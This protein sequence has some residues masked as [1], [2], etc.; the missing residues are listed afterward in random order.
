MARLGEGSSQYRP[1][2][3]SGGGGCGSWSEKAAERGR[4]ERGLQGEEG[5]GVHQQLQG[6]G[7]E[8]EEG[9]GPC[10]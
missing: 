2:G 5:K 6:G 9:L 3:P 1:S 7:R 8:Q 10:L 4:E